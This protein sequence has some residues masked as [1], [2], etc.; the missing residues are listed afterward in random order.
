[1]PILLT[2]ILETLFYLLSVPLNAAFALSTADGVRWGVGVSAF[3]LRPALRR[4]REYRPVK[5]RLKSGA[6]P[7]WQF[8]RRL[9]GARI[10]LR[11]RLGLGDAA[12]TAVACGALRGLAS[13]LAARAGRVEV[14]V[15]PVF[16]GEVCLELTGMIRLRAGQIMTAMALSQIENIHRRIARWTSIP[17]KA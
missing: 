5:R 12:A 15:T 11:G 17:L 3:E 8:I 10:R 4:A 2:A 14:D 16:A 7:S 9:R 6:K 13:A 1:M